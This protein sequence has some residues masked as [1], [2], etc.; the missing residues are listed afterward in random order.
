VVAAGGTDVV[1][2]KPV[3]YQPEGHRQSSVVRRPLRSYNGQRT[4]DKGRRE[5]LRDGR[6]VLRSDQSVAFQVASYDPAKPLV[7]DPVLAYSTYLGGT[8]YD[9]G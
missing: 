9:A 3:V 7:I 4:T 6:Y 8:D 2:H 1:F 5:A